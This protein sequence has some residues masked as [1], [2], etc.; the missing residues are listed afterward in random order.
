MLLCRLQNGRRRPCD[1]FAPA[2][3]IHDNA[4]R[5]R[6][7]ALMIHLDP[8]PKSVAPKGPRMRTTSSS[9]LRTMIL[10]QTLLSRHQD[11]R[12]IPVILGRQC[13]SQWP[14]QCIIM[15]DIGPAQ[16]AT[17]G[18]PE[19][20][21]RWTGRPLSGPCLLSRAA[22]VVFQAGPAPVYRRLSTS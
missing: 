22:L 13:K 18:S 16:I 10:L 1:C 19:K 5:S 8:G 17:C 21:P 9:N 14:D 4:E 11:R 12:K 7:A 20:E 2:L 15:A 6:A 3:L